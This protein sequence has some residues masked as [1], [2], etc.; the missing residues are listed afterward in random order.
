MVVEGADFFFIYGDVKWVEELSEGFDEPQTSLSSTGR[1][2]LARHFWRPGPATHRCAL[3]GDEQILAYWWGDWRNKEEIRSLI[4][5]TTSDPGRLFAEAWLEYGLE[6]L[7]RLRGVVA[8]VVF[9]HDASGPIVFRDKMGLNPIT[10]DASSP[11]GFLTSS[12]PDWLLALRRSPPGPNRDRL[13]RFLHSIDDDGDQDFLTGLRRLRPHEW[14]R[15]Q[16]RRIERNLYW[17][18]PTVYDMAPRDHSGESLEILREIMASSTLPEPRALAM[19]GGVDSPL[20]CALEIERRGDRD[21]PVASMIA[22]GLPST[23]ESQMIQR[24]AQ[25]LGIDPR[26]FSIGDLWPMQDPDDHIGPLA[27][28][29]HSSAENS[30]YSPFWQMIHQELGART[31]ISGVGADQL[32]S[33]PPIY[34]YRRLLSAHGLQGAQTLLGE[35]G[36]KK[37]VRHAMVTT[38]DRMQIG[39]RQRNALRHYAALVTPAKGAPPQWKSASWVKGAPPSSGG[40]DDLSPDDYLDTGAW[41]VSELRAWEWEWACRHIVSTARSSGLAQF[42]PTLDDRLWEYGLQIPPEIAMFRGHDKYVLRQIASRFLPD[43]V[44]FAPKRGGFDAVIERGLG[45]EAASTVRTLFQNS[46][47]E[48]LGFIDARQFLAAHALYAKAAAKSPAYWLGSFPLW[49]TI[50]AELWLRRLHQE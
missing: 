9:T 28:G 48:E 11:R 37:T 22:P 34:Y 39:P 49:R 50:S 6:L 20:L 40:D 13:N 21:L 47:L 29:P 16:P 14:M 46:R 18:P 44:A 5:A 38:L 30:Y 8:G 17:H 42:L 27:W 15:W 24:A 10:W 7:P 26:L 35:V 36:L 2:M 43:N 3:Y 1:P 32:F 23:D 12:D 31:V 19:S 33:T 45:V 4:G 25:A 41:R